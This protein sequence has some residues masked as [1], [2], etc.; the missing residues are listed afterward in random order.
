MVAHIKK[1]RVLGSYDFAIKISQHNFSLTVGIVTIA[2]IITNFKFSHCIC[3]GTVK[4]SELESGGIK[5]A[6]VGSVFNSHK[7]SFR[8]CSILVGK[9][10]WVY[11]GFGLRLGGIVFYVKTDGV[12][13]SKNLGF[14]ASKIKGNNTIFIANIYI[15]DWVGNGVFRYYNG[16]CK[17]IYFCTRSYFSGD[18]VSTCRGICVG[19][20]IFIWSSSTISKSP[21][22]AVKILRTVDI[23]QGAL[24]YTCIFKHNSS[25]KKRLYKRGQTDH[26]SSTRRKCDSSIGV[27][28]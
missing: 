9:R 10:E 2:W 3:N 6:A 19:G 27:I 18:S 12:L 26:T 5:T 20:T 21:K 1:C 25:Q 22:D 4:N 8:G 16:F 23:E 11:I 7:N 24:I 13:R 14:R 17:G 15:I 28:T